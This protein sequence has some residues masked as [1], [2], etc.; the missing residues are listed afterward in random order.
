[1][2]AKTSS[3]VSGPANWKKS[4]ASR[5]PRPAA[6]AR[7]VA[8]LGDRHGREVEGA[9]VEALLGEPDAVAALA[10]GDRQRFLARL[11]QVGVLLQEFVRRGTEQI[12]GRGKTRFPAFEFRHHRLRD[13]AE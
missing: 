4:A 3:R 5:P 10:V 1:M 12:A 8:R 7:E 11:Q 2:P 13:G 6:P 9:D